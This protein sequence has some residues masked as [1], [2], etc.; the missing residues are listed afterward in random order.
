MAEILAF[1]TPPKPEPAV[2][3]EGTITIADAD[4]EGH[5]RIA[6]EGVGEVA[7]SPHRLLAL[8]EQAKAKTS[9]FL[10]ERGARA[11]MDAIRAGRPG[12][13][14]V[15]MLRPRPR[16]GRAKR[17]PGFVIAD[18]DTGANDEGEREERT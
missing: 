3:H 4:S 15:V 10:S 6:F 13:N 2:L 5:F 9:V 11:L 8:A 17:G 18:P 14:N 16:R 12:P 7:L 1:P